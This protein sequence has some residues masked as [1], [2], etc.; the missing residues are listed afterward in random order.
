M[1]SKVIMSWLNLR[2]DFQEVLNISYANP[3]GEHAGSET[4]TL[5]V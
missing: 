2:L 4:R 1:L 5:A 3:T